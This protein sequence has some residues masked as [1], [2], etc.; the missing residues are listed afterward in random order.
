MG[1]NSIG[2]LFMPKNVIFYELF[3]DVAATV[4]QMGKLLRQL[5]HEPDADKRA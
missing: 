1:L 2:K 3:E 5:V 4:D